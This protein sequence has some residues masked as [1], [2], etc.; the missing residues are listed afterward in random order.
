[1]STTDVRSLLNIMKVRESL[2]DDGITPPHPAV[3]A[4][5]R[6]LVSRLSVIEPEERIEVSCEVN[7]LHARYIR[8][9]TGEVLAEIQIDEPE[10]P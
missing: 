4:A 8:A 1:M 5:T 6:Q 10:A 9:L 2:Q 7:P 3:R